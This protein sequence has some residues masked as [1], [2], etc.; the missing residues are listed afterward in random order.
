VPDPVGRETELDVVDGFLEDGL[1]GLRALAILGEPGIGKTTVWEETV[2][3]ARD[4]GL[5]VVAA[6]PAAAEAKLAFSGLT[7]LLT[8]RPTLDD[9]LAADEG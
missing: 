5:T 6:R 8:V 4:R 1:P 7:D 3:R 2:R 9:A